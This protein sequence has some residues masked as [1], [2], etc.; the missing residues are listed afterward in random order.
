VLLI[1]FSNVFL[2]PASLAR[3][4]RCFLS[5]SSGRSAV[6]ASPL[7]YVALSPY[8]VSR[9][10]NPPSS[11]YI[12]FSRPSSVPFSPS[13]WTLCGGFP[14]LFYSSLT[15]IGTPFVRARQRLPPENHFFPSQGSAGT[16]DFSGGTEGSHRPGWFDHSFLSP[17]LPHFSVFAV[18]RRRPFPTRFYRGFSPAHGGGV[19][20]FSKIS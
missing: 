16:V 12:H 13:P 6:A 1:S 18:A 14:P 9:T 5:G 15:K 17:L 19:P 7:C 3:S 2:G 4:L 8:G 20:P 11:N 10:K